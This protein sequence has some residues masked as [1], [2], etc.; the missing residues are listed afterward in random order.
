MA[1]ERCKRLAIVDGI[2]YQRIGGQSFYLQELF[3]DDELRAH[4]AACVSAQ[5]AVYEFVK[6]DSNVER[7]FVEDL[8]KNTS[9]KLYAKLPQQ[10]TGPTPLGSDN[11]DGA[12]VIEHDGKE[13]LY[14]V[15]ETK[16]SSFGDDLRHKE[17]AKIECG[18]AH[19]KAVGEGHQ[20]PAKF[21]WGKALD[22]LFATQVIGVTK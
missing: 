22:Q 11:P 15:V 16:G 13:Q 3:A 4:L 1:I 6:C 14:F 5:K 12:I 20:N 10:F 18:K 9:V 2:K 17:R 19:F 7:Q 21:A 8:E